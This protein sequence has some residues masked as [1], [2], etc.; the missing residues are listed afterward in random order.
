VSDEQPDPRLYRV[1]RNDEEQ[2]SIWWHDRPLPDGWHAE[3]PEGSRDE[4]LARIGRLWTDMRPASLR[5]RMEQRAA[6]A[7][8]GTNGSPPGELR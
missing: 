3:G 4:C 8:T 2:Y 7:G 1:V 6:Q 5:R